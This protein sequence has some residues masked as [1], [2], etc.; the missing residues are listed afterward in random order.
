MRCAKKETRADLDAAVEAADL[1]ERSAASAAEAAGEAVAR[2]FFV[3]GEKSAEVRRG[4]SRKE[5][6]S[7]GRE[8]RCSFIV[9]R[10]KS[11]DSETRIHA[12]SSKTVIRHT[13]SYDTRMLTS[14][15]KGRDEFA[16][17]QRGHSA[18][19]RDHQQRRR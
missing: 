13:C 5:K 18:A 7:R 3:V 19:R 14:R 12:S 8:A 10:K 11:L 1:I 2:F 9:I 6:G 15:N 4:D 17:H 16:L